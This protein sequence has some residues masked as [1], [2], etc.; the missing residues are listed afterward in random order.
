MEEAALKPSVDLGN[1]ESIKV[2][3]LPVPSLSVRG[4]F[5]VYSNVMLQGTDQIDLT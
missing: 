4:T 2:T 5:V 1:A 3:V